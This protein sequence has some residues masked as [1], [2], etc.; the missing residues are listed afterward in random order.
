MCEILVTGVISELLVIVSFIFKL[1]L[2]YKIVSKAYLVNSA[3]Y[4]FK[5]FA[6]KNSFKS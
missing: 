4:F 3:Q 1:K 2:S 6:K 5:K